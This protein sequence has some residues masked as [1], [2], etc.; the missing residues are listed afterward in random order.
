M[1]GNTKLVFVCS[2]NN[3]TANAMPPEQLRRIARAL[4]PRALLVVDEAY[5][6][7]ADVD[8]LSADIDALP[9]LAVLKT[10]SK[11]HGLAGARVGALLAAP[12]VIALTRKVIPPYA[13]TELTVE[14]V[15]PLLQPAALAAMR[16]RV[17]GVLAERT[18]LAQGLAHSPLI[19]RVWPSDANFLLVDCVDADQVLARVRG[20]GLIIRDVRQSAL[21]R[22]LRISVGTLPRTS[23]CWRASHEQYPTQVPVHRSRRHADRGAAGRTGR[24]PGEG[25][26]DPRRDQ[27]HCGAGRR[28]LPLVMV[29]N[30]DGLGTPAFPR[31]RFALVAG[32][33]A[34]RC[35][36][37]QGI[38][39][40]QV[41][42]CPHLPA[43]NC[44]CRKPKAG[45]LG[46]FLQTMTWIWRPAPSSAIAIRTWNS[47]ATWACA[48]CAC[49]RNGPPEQSWPAVANELLARR[50]AVERATNAKPT[51]AYRWIWTPRFPSTCATGIGFFD[52]MLEQ[53]AKH[54]GFALRLDCKGDLDIDEHHTVEDCALA[55]GE[56][57][58]Q[59]LG[60]KRGIGRYGFVLPMDEARVQVAI[61][62][63]GRP[64]CRIRRRVRPRARSAACPPNWCRIS[65]A[66]SAEALGAAIHMSVPARTPTT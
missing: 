4:A 66:R 61:D 45:L 10:L 8:S 60:D 28:R 27:P 2:P 49:S 34:A 37:S 26:L 50:A 16:E 14:A 65:S 58:R 35:S 20:A 56:A 39:F 52:H 64:Y 42:I 51:S 18:R 11:A 12:D 53:V 32:L 38:G 31:E 13:I 6:D 44:D 19:A 59:A 40:A 55:L 23:A 9:N 62:L 41:C 30:Q 15:V 17:A 57:L 21:P 47:R 43:D 24:Q 48:G 29:T 54:G 46:S 33:R 3:P 1:D 5:I 22:S 36:R 25:A 7:F 63:S